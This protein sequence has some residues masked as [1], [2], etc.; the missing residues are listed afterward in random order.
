MVEQWCLYKLG[1][2]SGVWWALPQVGPG[3]SRFAVL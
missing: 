3:V 2:N 1:I